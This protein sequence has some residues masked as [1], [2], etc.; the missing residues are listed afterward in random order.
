MPAL[1]D[2][3]LLSDDNAAQKILDNN[4]LYEPNYFSMLLGLFTV[5]ALIY[6]SAIVYQKLCKVKL[7]DDNSQINKI[8]IISTTSLGQG[9]N[10]H[11]IK[12]NDTYSLIGATQNQI[13]HIKD[14]SLEYINSLKGNEDGKDD[15][16]SK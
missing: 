13:T 8:E 3:E 10:L 9:K 11:I 7:K 15:K 4:N 14:F 6:L 1:A 12:V 16:N 2:S 5:I